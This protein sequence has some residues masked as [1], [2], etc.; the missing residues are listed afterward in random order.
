MYFL[1]A[2]AE[3]D[4]SQLRHIQG[5][6]RQAVKT[7]HLLAN[8]HIHTSSWLPLLS[9]TNLDGQFIALI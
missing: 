9:F 8:H 1:V 2:D 6:K 4:V 5:L 3:T 7:C